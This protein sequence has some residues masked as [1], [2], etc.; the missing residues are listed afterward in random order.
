MIKVQYM[1]VKYH[2]KTPFNNQYTLEKMKDWKVKQ[3]VSGGGYLQKRE[4]KL[5]R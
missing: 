2:G 5:R 1:H 3:V 4:G